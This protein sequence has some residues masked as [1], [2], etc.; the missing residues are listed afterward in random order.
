[1]KFS[2]KGAP[3]AQKKVTESS[4][5]C[6]FQ[7][8][9]DSPTPYH[10]TANILACFEQ[11]DFK[12]LQETAAWKLNSGGKYVVTRNDGSLV[13][14][15]VGSEAKRAPEMVILGA[16][17]DSPCLRLKPK[18][19]IKQSGYLQLGVETYG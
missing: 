7:F 13:A 2:E 19:E 16:H 9:H 12:R 8:L 4:L 18:A 15:I 1:F 14:F 10:A 17:T 5:Q 3:M 11:A 6:F